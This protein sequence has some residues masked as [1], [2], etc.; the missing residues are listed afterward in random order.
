MNK[1]NSNS[2]FSDLEQEHQF[3]ANRKYFI[4]SI[5][6]VCVIVL[7]VIAIY[8]LWNMT[9]VA[10][11]FNSFIQKLSP[12]IVA[13]FIAYFMHPLVKFI[14]NK[15]MIGIFKSNHNKLNIGLSI[16]LAYIFVIACITL[17]LFFI[18]PEVYYSIVDLTETVSKNI[19]K[20]SNKVIQTIENL[21]ERFPW[22]N[23]AEIEKQAKDSIPSF[24]KITTD[25][26]TYIFEKAINIS[27]SVISAV[28]SLIV[29]ITV[30]IYMILDKKNLA[31]HAC[32]FTYAIMPKNRAYGLIQ[33]IK[34]CN[35]I[36]YK[37]VITFI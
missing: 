4:I 13:F 2:T 26:V 18:L 10:S 28:L 24:M 23:W 20:W 35:T 25:L 11:I 32:R 8:V 16:L 21:E 6:A 3:E 19:P 30:S 31:K 15:I 7:S 37:F 14:R 12:F 27:I 29:S 36:F 33:T 34:E 17:I 9:N 1:N 5:Y 22:F